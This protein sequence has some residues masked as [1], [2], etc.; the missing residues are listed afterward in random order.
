MAALPEGAQQNREW[1]TR[2]LTRGH[3]AAAGARW[4]FSRLPA[5]TRCKFCRTPFS[6]PGAK[7]V[8]L[9]GWRPSRK[10]PRICAT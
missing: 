6:G 7:V 1:W 2:V 4:V 8:G 5:E 9:F 3:P 10:N